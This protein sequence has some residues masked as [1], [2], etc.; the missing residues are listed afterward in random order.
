[1]LMP[2]EGFWEREPARKRTQLGSL[3]TARQSASTNPTAG[4]MVGIVV[5]IVSV[6]CS[7]HLIIDNDAIGLHP[8]HN[9][10]YPHSRRLH[11]GKGSS[12]SQNFSRLHPR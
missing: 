6:L 8:R 12:C 1:M 3:L 11:H 5:C 2:R 9:R 4:T 7:Y 10:S